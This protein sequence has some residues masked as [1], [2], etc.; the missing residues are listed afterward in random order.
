MT[1]FFLHPLNA[2]HALTP[3]LSD[4]RAAVRM[5]VGL[6]SDHATIPDFDLVVRAEQGSGTTDW[7]MSGYAP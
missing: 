3:V 1:T 2:R 4:L 5:A 7:G 6:A